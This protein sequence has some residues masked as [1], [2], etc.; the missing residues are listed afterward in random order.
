MQLWRTGK[1]EKNREIIN[2]PSRCII[3]ILKEY[4]FLWAIFSSLLA[5]FYFHMRL[6]EPRV[7]FFFSLFYAYYTYISYCVNKLT[8][9]VIF[10]VFCSNAFDFFA[11]AF[12]LTLIIKKVDF[13]A[14]CENS[15]RFLLVLYEQCVHTT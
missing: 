4:I 15:M 8:V 12:P 3:L 5:Y 13:H 6:L 7:S 9:P 2:Q 1:L 14:L 10:R 11:H